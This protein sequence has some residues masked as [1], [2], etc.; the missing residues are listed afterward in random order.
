MGG[1]AAG[2]WGV[3]VGDAYITRSQ[4]RRRDPRKEKGHI[5]GAAAWERAAVHHR[6]GG[7]S[8]A[9]VYGKMTGCGFVC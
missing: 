8:F 5:E 6:G 4:W 3:T 2:L 7:D 9:R 1:Y